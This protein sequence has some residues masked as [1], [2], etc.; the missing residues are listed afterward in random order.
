MTY[1]F[2]T[3]TLVLM[4]RGT[5]IVS[6]KSP[7][8]HLRANQA[9]TILGK[10]RAASKLGHRLALSA[11][12]V[13]ELEFG[14]CNSDDYEVEISATRNALA[15]FELLDFTVADCCEQYGRIRHQLGRVG[16][17]IGANDLLIAAHALALDATI[18]TN[19]HREFGRVPGLRVESWLTAQA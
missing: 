6:A 14:A 18:V 2:D 10:C 5:K 11:I 17:L 7:L 16:K 19:N 4:M 15:A 3:D 13:A 12:T 8:Q 1:L 9:A